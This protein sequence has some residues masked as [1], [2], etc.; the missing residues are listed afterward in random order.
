MLS[1]D[2]VDPTSPQVL[3]INSPRSLE[4]IRSEGYQV[5]DLV[6]R[7]PGKKPREIREM[8]FK[9][10]K[11]RWKTVQNARKCL[12]ERPE[13]S[14]KDL[15]RTALLNEAVSQTISRL[16]E[17]EHLRLSRLHAN[18]HT[19]LLPQLPASTRSPTPPR[20]QKHL[21]SLAPTLQKTLKSTVQNSPFRTYEVSVKPEVEME[22]SDSL[23]ATI[24]RVQKMLA[25]R[26]EMK[27]KQEKVEIPA[28][29]TPIP[30]C[31]SE[32]ISE[33]SISSTPEP[34]FPRNLRLL[35]SL[36]LSKNTKI[37]Q[38]RD[39]WTQKLAKIQ[40]FQE[41]K[42]KL[43]DS[44]RNEQQMKQILAENRFE[45]AFFEKYSHI[46]Q[47]ISEDSQ[48]QEKSQRRREIFEAQNEEEKAKKAEI[49]RENEKKAQEK[50]DF[51]LNLR[52]NRLEMREKRRFERS[53]ERIRLENERK[54]SLNRKLAE[55]EAETSVF[56]QLKEK[57]HRELQL[58]QK[59]RKKLELEKWENSEK[60]E[61]LRRERGKS[62]REMLN[63]VRESQE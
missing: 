34:S 6:Y 53:L 2:S 60:L 59:L 14:P 29:F 5:S 15:A 50:R 41:N 56:Q 51:M 20:P 4:A 32:K 36:D 33:F 22:L 52:K 45:T 39:L 49:L 8:R 31:L 24:K 12:L 57:K 61:K 42:D 54:E 46:K 43:A 37:Q 1:L 7:E 11:E 28:T 17:K 25:E 55:I 19:Q 27:R 44:L 63:S 47:L 38:K 58:K 10:W 40:Q 9:R 21:H 62:G 26:E 3:Q 48:K 35:Q 13:Q 18:R 30:V 16:R 23:P